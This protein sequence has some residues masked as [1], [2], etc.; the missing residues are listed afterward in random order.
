MQAASN[1]SY[2]LDQF[3]KTITILYIHSLKNPPTISPNILF[4]ED[5]YQRK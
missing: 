2:E 5:Q 3:L 4:L 1:I